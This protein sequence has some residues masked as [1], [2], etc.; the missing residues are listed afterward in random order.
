MSKNSKE[1]F[2]EKWGVSYSS[3]QSWLRRH[4]DVS[5]SMLPEDQMIDLMAYYKDNLGNFY[6]KYGIRYCPFRDWI[7]KVKGVKIGTL[8]GDYSEYI[9]E[10]KW[11]AMKNKLSKDEMW[12]LL[13]RTIHGKA[14]TEKEEKVINYLSEAQEAEG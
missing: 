10:Y 1:R 6:S 9:D 7:E 2:R 3:F 5:P 13:W 8:N 12:E 14:L 4:Y 11:I